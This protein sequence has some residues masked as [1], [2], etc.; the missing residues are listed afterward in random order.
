MT[1]ATMATN[2]VK[3]NNEGEGFCSAICVNNA[4]W[5]RR[6]FRIAANAAMVYPS[7]TRL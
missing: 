5:Q 2:S 7:C 3:F 1:E 6:F 4:K